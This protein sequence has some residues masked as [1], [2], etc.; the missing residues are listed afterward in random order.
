MSSSLPRYKSLPITQAVQKEVTFYA[1]NW[2]GI[3]ISVLLLPKAE[4]DAMKE[5]HKHRVVSSFLSASS[6]TRLNPS[7]SICVD[8]LF[9]F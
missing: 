3:R 4:K 7:P 9:L 2:T 6:S 8:E 1:A 5:D